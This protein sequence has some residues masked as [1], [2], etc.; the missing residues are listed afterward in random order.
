MMKR[1]LKKSRRILQLLI[2]FLLCSGCGTP[3]DPPSI[4]R[5]CEREP[6]GERPAATASNQ[7]RIRYAKGFDVSYHD[8]CKIV[9][10]FEPGQAPGSKGTATFV[11]VPR[12]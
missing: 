9:T 11:L 5:A 12:G 8:G 1:R 4:G 2:F 10:V 7:C 6:Q 3:S